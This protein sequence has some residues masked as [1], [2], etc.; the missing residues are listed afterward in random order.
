MNFLIHL[1]EYS[2]V[3]S[4]TGQEESEFFVLYLFLLIGYTVFR[5]RFLRVFFAALLCCFAY[6][7]VIG[8]EWYRRGLAVPMGIIFL[9]MMTIVVCGWLLGTL[10]RLLRQV[11][12]AAEERAAA[13]AKSE[14]TL[15]TI[16]DTA[17][18]PILVYDDH[19]IVTAANNKTCEFLGMSRDHILGKEF[20]GFLFDDGSLGEKLAEARRREEYQ[21]EQIFV[22]P[23]G[24]ERTVDLRIQSF[25]RGQQTF[26]VVVAHDIT[27]R[28]N[29]QEATHL[30][31]VNLA[32][33]NRELQQVNEMKTGLLTAVSQRIKSPL[34]AILGY[35]DMLLNDE[36]G[37]LGTEQRKVLQHSRRISARIFRLIDEAFG[38]PAPEAPRP[39]SQ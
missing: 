37:A 2:V 15:R 33:L 6:G 27:E 19:E 1:S 12:A 25:I 31:N 39:K 13:L 26:S 22:G 30:A 21:G 14:A 9:K 4:F 28:K 32:R 17:A 10:S 18:D 8:V 3:V 24:Q 34:T 38:A 20:R 35:L 23:D 7:V 5:R 11:E 29:L 36:L 16:L